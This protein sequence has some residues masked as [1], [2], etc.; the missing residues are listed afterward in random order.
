MSL[1]QSLAI[2]RTAPET[3]WSKSGYNAQEMD[4]LSQ[5]QNKLDADAGN[6]FGLSEDAREDIASTQAGITETQSSFNKLSADA[7]YHYA[8]YKE[9]KEKYKD[10]WPHKDK[11]LRRAYRKSRTLGSEATSKAKALSLDELAPNQ[12]AA[13]YRPMMLEAMANRF[14]PGSRP[15]TAAVGDRSLGERFLPTHLPEWDESLRKIE[16]EREKAYSDL[17]GAQTTTLGRYEESK[18]ALKAA[19]DKL[20]Y[21]G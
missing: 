13:T 3:D 4:V 15:Q 16:L 1:L 14:L 18:A 12:E 11:S 20:K 7:A 21:Q 2:G 10:R 9:Q 5:Y 17:I 8:K 6:F 19:Q